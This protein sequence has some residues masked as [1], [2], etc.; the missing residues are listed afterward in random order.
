MLFCKSICETQYRQGDTGSDNS[1]KFVLS[2]WYLLE[3]QLVIKMMTRLCKILK[4]INITVQQGFS[5]KQDDNTYI[6]VRYHTRHKR[7]P[8]IWNIILYPSI[9]KD[10]CNVIVQILEMTLVVNLLAIIVKYR[11]NK[12]Y[13][14]DYLQ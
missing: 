10:S 4:Q 1:S 13:G 14:S 8:V 7:Y 2:P 3:R 9:G 5:K 11:R 6:Q 12:V